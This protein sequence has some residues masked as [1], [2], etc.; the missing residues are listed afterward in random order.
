MEKLKELGKNWKKIG[1]K[2]KKK[3]EKKLKEK[4]EKQIEKMK[5]WKEEEICGKNRKKMGKIQL[6]SNDENDKKK[7][8]SA[9]MIGN[10]S[11]RFCVKNVN[12]RRVPSSKDFEYH[13]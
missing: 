3:V 8:V 9:W 13:D 1:E 5:I 12:E 10:C 2:L 4:I 11:V 6:S 7:W